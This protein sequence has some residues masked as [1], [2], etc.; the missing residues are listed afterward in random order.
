MDTK[1]TLKM[2]RITPLKAKRVIDL[3]KGKRAADALTSLRF[4]PYRAAK[5]VEKL[6]KSAIA[7]A[8]NLNKHV[9]I[10]KLKIKTA[11]V[12]QGPVMK[13]METRAMGR[14]NIIKKR[15]S[16]ITIILT[17]EIKK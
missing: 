5:H 4:M 2:A 8:E 3:I 17:E 12:G 16:H 1:A 11:Y 14:A 9:D 13:R 15:T 6:L 10:D 7:N